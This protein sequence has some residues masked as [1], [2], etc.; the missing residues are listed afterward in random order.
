MEVSGEQETYSDL[1]GRIVAPNLTPDKETGAGTWTDD[2]FTRALRE[3]IGHDGRA[4]FPLMPYV[5]FR[6]LSDED[7]AP[8]TNVG[9]Q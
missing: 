4:L 7:V 2:M 3:G 5:N 6:K 8:V 9:L 1:P